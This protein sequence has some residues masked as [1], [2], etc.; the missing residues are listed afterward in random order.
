[1]SWYFSDPYDLEEDDH[2]YAGYWRR[3]RASDDTY[4][5]EYRPF[6]L[7]VDSAIGYMETQIETPLYDAAFL[8]FMDIA[9]AAQGSLQYE[10]ELK[11][12]KFLS[13]PPELRLNI[14]QQYISSQPKEEGWSGECSEDFSLKL[15]VW[16][17]PHELSILDFD[18]EDN[19]A[20]TKYA[21]WLPALAFAKKQVF[22]EV[23]VYMLRTTKWFDFVYMYDRPCKIVTWFTH[24]LSTFPHDEAF[25]TIKRINFPYAYHYNENRFGK[26]I[27]E[28]NPDVQFM[29]R[30]P[31][32][33]I[34][35]MTFSA[36]ALTTSLNHMYWWSRDPRDL[37]DFLTFFQLHPILEHK[38][39]KQFHL[40]RVFAVD[41]DL[42]ERNCLQK[43]GEW[44]VKGFR[45]K[46]DRTVDVYINE[47]LGDF[48]DRVV[49]RKVIV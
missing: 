46:Q 33:E 35:A 12:H 8:E 27:D 22:G 26:V 47:R 5:L 44:I 21:P 13:L 3:M 49:G 31:N 4:P 29:L 28:Q 10:R 37:D 36:Y 24:F 2:D 16:N 40:D 11:F 15:N 43:F 45:E 38:N 1:M 19:L 42:N 32:L 48:R 25:K 17:W 23:A 30:C 41:F 7:L 34:M 6:R 14:Y 39:I 20:A 9:A 18:N